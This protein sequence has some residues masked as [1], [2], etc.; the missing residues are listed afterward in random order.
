MTLA[1]DEI[2]LSRLS[3]TSTDHG[4]SRF[5]E[6]KFHSDG[7]KVRCNVERRAGR[8]SWT[9][10]Y[11]IRERYQVEGREVRDMCYSDGELAGSAGRSVGCKVAAGCFEKARI[12]NDSAPLYF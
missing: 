2:A 6:F 11:S 1:P 8:C 7:E 9:D 12:C 5:N 10:K 4:F 3:S